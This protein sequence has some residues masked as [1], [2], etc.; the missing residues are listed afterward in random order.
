MAGVPGQTIRVV[1][2]LGVLLAVAGTPGQA[3]G[4]A[5]QNLVPK[6]NTT[7]PKSS[8]PAP[9]AHR[10]KRA[11]AAKP[12]PQPETVAAVVPPTPPPPDWPVNDKAVPASVDWNGRVLRI[13]AT[14]SSLQ[15]ILADVS[16]ATGV[17]V[18]GASSDQRVYG[19]YGPAPARDV[20]NELLE[21]SGY[22][23]LMIGD[24]GQGTPRSLVLTVKSAAPAVNPGLNAQARQSSDEE[25]EEPEPAEPADPAM[26]RGPGMAPMQ[27]GA[28]RSPQQIMQ[29]IEQRRLQMQQQQQQQGAPVTPQP[30]PGQPND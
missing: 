23:V 25:P 28:N 21:G 7:S 26:R 17:K 4:T 5:G 12:E 14:N 9:P 8:A 6:P 3:Q 1:C 10:K 11:Q 16:T 20:L 27:P 15:Q 2:A 18:D 22:N 30:I 19:S 29:E 24:Q 13:S